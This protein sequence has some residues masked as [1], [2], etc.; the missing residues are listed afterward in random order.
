MRQNIVLLFL[1][2]ITTNLYTQEFDGGIIL[3]INTS[4]VSG[5]NLGG[6]NKAGLLIG[7]YVNRNISS[8]LNMQMEINY[9]QKGS[10]NPNINDIEHPN[11]S[12]PYIILNY[13]EIPIVLKILQNNIS[14]IEF[15][16]TTAVL[17]NGF[18]KNNYGIMDNY[19][20]PLF[21]KYDIGCL[22]GFNYKLTENISLTTRFVNSI[23]PIG[24]EDVNSI[25]LFNSSKKGKYNSL[26]SFAIYYNI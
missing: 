3:G 18:Y 11:Y 7:G 26:I 13:I 15:G 17:I 23:L 9:I 25:I 20:I 12:I 1:L 21:I 22:L 24:S 4:Q 14:K 2:F 10:G 5:D 6:F 19:N 8:I 16:T